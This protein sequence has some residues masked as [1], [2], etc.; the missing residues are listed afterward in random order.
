MAIVL[1]GRDDLA[2]DAGVDPAPPPTFAGIALAQNVRSPDEVDAVLRRA[3]QAGATITKPAARTFY[4]GYAG[5]F[6]DPEGHLWEVAHNPGFRLE[7]DGALT[8]PDFH[9]T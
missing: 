3:E 5:Y 1:W 8:L 6:R 4:G 7:P 9:Q 2:G